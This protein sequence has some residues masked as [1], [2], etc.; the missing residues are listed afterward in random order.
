MADPFRHAGHAE[1]MCSVWPLQGREPA[2]EK[3]RIL[4]LVEDDADDEP[5]AVCDLCNGRGGRRG[6]CTAP[7]REQLLAG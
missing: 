1:A 7:A 2:E 5:G 3:A 4:G 6:G